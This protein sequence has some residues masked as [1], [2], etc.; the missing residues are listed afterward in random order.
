MKNRTKPISDV[1]TGHRTASVCNVTNIA[2]ELQRPL[3]W[4]PEKELFVGD[5]YANLMVGRPYR[6][7]WDY[8]NF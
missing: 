3:L 1:E 7:K 6:G 2:Y 8:T 5:D 4:N